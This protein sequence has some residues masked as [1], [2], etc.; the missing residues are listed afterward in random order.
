MVSEKQRMI[1]GELYSPQDAELVKDRIRARK[2]TRLYN[3]TIETDMAE[4]TAI[5]KNF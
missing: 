3:Q 4:R 1:S 5:L 2:L